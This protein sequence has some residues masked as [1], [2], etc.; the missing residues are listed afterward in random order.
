M[1]PAER[2]T[3]ADSAHDCEEVK[4]NLLHLL[5]MQHRGTNVDS[6]VRCY[7]EEFGSKLDVRK[8]G[9]DSLLDMLKTVSE[10][11]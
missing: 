9:F 6:L 7:R 11:R 3:A 4:R 8:Y 1:W 2:G 10:L 5:K